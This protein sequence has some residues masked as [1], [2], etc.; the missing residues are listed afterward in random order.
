MKF[1]A[2]L[3]AF[4]LTV[5]SIA[6]ASKL[7]T[8]EATY[9]YHAPANQSPEE[10]M[11]IALERAKIQAI[12]D[13]FGTLVSQENTTIVKNGNDGSTTSFFSLGTSDVRGE[14]IE[15]IGEPKC[16]VQFVNN[17]MVVTISVKGKAREITAAKVNFVAQTLRNH[18]N[19]ADASTDFRDG[20]DMYLHFRSPVAGYVAVYLLPGDG[21]AFCLL[22]YQRMTTGIQ[23]V[24]ANDDYV[25]FSID[26]APTNQKALVD[27]YVLTAS[28]AV[29]H[30]VLY[31][32]FSPKLFYKANDLAYNVS[33]P[34][35]LSERDFHQWVSKIRTQDKDLQVKMIQIQI[36]K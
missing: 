9:V 29:E 13:E 7:K 11:K 21:N 24:N 36:R 12:A 34:R 1:F 3:F 25:F 28:K 15:T 23:A 26:K 5:T 6:F 10:A 18:P 27:E 31:V 30:N 19:S 8:V 22:P 33:L 17:M 20:N 16:E 35:Q 14:W 4:A 2:C 32:L